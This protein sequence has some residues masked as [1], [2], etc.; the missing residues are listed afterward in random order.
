MPVIFAAPIVI[1][2]VAVTGVVAAPAAAIVAAESDVYVD[3]NRR[4]KTLSEQVQDPSSHRPIQ[5]AVIWQRCCQPTFTFHLPSYRVVSHSSHFPDIP[6]KI[7]TS[8]P[9][10][11]LTPHSNIRYPLYALAETCLLICLSSETIAEN[12]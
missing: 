7:C 1:A 11:P 12:M 8:A 5:D 9:T 2:A 6:C 3:Q 10:A 4:N